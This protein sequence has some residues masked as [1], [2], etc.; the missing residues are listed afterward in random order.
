MAAKLL[1]YRERHEKYRT[2]VPNGKQNEFIQLDSFIRIF[3]AG[4]GVGKSALMVNVI[5]NLTAPPR[6][7]NQWFT[8]Y[9]DFKRPNR[10]RIVSTNTNIQQNIIPELKKWLPAGKWSCEKRG[11]AYEAYWKVGDCEFDIMTYEQDEAEFESVTLDW[12]L[13]DEPPPYRIYAASVARFR[14]GGFIGI[15]MTPLSDAAW[16]YDELILKDNGARVRVTYAEVEDNCKQHGVRGILDHSHIEQMIAQ[17]TDDEKEARTK[18]RFMHLRG[19]IYKDYGQIHRIKPFALSPELYTIYMALDPHPRTPHAC[20]WMAVDHNGTKFVIDE[21]F[22]AC[23]TDEL[24]AK[25]L[26]LESSKGYNVVRRIIDPMAFVKDQTKDV[27]IL[28][29]QLSLKGLYFEAA[30]KDLTAGILRVQQ[31]LQ[32][33]IK[34]GVITKSPELY[35]FDTCSRT[36]YEFKRYVWDEWSPAMSEKRNPRS[37]PR[38]RDDHMME[39]LYR[40]LLLEMTHMYRV[41]DDI[42]IP[43]NPFSGY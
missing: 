8:T 5:A 37:T 31:S 42:T 9:R 36:E 3:S 20:L 12:L 6:H 1:L 16:L 24:A 27:P 38:D 14:F 34:D 30:S 35:V 40:L 25:I 21:L 19:L 10:G 32:Y 23:N 29:E 28:Q 41:H 15:F 7:T 11:K 17:Y 39:C 22:T 18:G 13:F 33:G 26:A 43:A 2:F 4:N